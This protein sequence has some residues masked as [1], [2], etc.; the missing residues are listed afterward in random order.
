M[1]CSRV[2]GGQ[3]MSRCDTGMASV[4]AT[5]S[6]T[7]LASKRYNFSGFAQKNFLKIS[8]D[9]SFNSA[10]G[11]LFHNHKIDFLGLRKKSPKMIIQVAPHCLM[12]PP[13]SGAW[14]CAK[15]V[16]KPH[17]QLRESVM[18]VDD[19]GPPTLGMCHLLA[20]HTSTS[21]NAIFHSIFQGISY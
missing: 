19:H 16:S 15:C 13:I 3:C 8:R 6:N 5:R 14:L 10:S 7:P 21:Q 9:S 20:I 4:S 18:Y 2:G 17:T 12:C 11:T 1:G